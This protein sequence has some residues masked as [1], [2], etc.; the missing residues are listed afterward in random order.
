MLTTTGAKTGQQRTMPVIAVPD[1]DHLVVLRSNWGQ[2]Q[3]P[4]WYDN[5]RA[6][7]TATVTVSGV[8][9]R[10]QAHEALGGSATARFTRLRAELCRGGQLRPVWAEA[11]G[12]PRPAPPLGP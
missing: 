6:H 2:R 5:L 11:A 1:D 9:R 3:H 4:A 7:P 8:P 12:G 10:V